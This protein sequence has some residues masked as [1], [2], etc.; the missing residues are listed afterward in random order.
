MLYFS[1]R[2][3]LYRSSRMLHEI[4]PRRSLRCCI[5]PNFFKAVEADMGF[6]MERKVSHTPKAGLKMRLLSSLEGTPVIKEDFGEGHITSHDYSCTP[7]LVR[8]GES[9]L[10]AKDGAL[11][12]PSK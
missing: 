2:K 7:G 9:S 1:L 10:G 4:M 3:S 8:S 12:K 11:H 6:R 5:L